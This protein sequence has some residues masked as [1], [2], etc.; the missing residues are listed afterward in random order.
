MGELQE[1][2]GGLLPG[3]LAVALLMIIQAYTNWKEARRKNEET[4]LSRWQREVKRLEKKVERDAKE[5]EYMEQCIDFWRN[6]SADL[7]YNLRI[8]NVAVPPMG[9]MPAR[10]DLEESENEDG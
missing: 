10:P 9:P 4:I 3:G 8:N 1:L 7:E 5:K 6:R 2:I